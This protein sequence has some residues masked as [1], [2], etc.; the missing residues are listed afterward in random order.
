MVVVHF[1][2]TFDFRSEG[3]QAQC[4]SQFVEV[5]EFRF[6]R[7]G[8]GWPFGEISPGKCRRMGIGRR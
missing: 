8:E 2:L 1:H 6:A 3:K 5:K 7:S 4:L